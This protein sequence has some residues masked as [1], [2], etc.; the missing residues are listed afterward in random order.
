MTEPTDRAPDDVA[1]S[2]PA[3]SGPLAAAPARGGV[4]LTGRAA[5]QAGALALLL[6]G[7]WL[8]VSPVVFS[9]EVEL[10]PVLSGIAVT[11]LA[12]LKFAAVGSR[13]LALL[14]GVV[15]LWLIASPF[16]LDEARPET[17]YLIALGGVVL[18]LSLVT[19]ATGVEVERRSR[20]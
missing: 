20:A 11:A 3:Q 7:V 5:G 18:V 15:G 1:G 2:Q 17:I 6:L 19:V 12:L 13:P 4:G 9:Y 14:L 10:N 8:I 16:V